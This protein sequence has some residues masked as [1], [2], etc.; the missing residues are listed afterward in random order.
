MTLIFDPPS[1]RRLPGVRFEAPPQAPDDALP[2]MDIAFFVGFAASGPLTAAVAVESLTEFETVFGAGIVLARDAVTGEPVDGLLHPAVRGF[3][4]QGGR[5]CWVLRVAGAEVRVSRFA[6]PSLLTAWRDGPG[7]AWRF[8]PATLS[9]RSPGSG[10]DA[11]RV[12]ARIVAAPAPT[13]VASFDGAI[14][15]LRVATDLAVAP[16]A[17]DVMR[18]TFD[19][20]RLYGRVAAA[21]ATDPDG[22]GVPVRLVTLAGLVALRPIT[23]TWPAPIPEAVALP[24]LEPFS[25][26]VTQG[27]WLT[28]G[29]LCIGVRIAAQRLPQAG[30]VAELTFDDASRNAWMA[31]DEVELFEATG[32]DGQIKATLTG[33][34]WE[35]AEGAWRV[36]IDAW[37]SAGEA[38]T[39]Q[40]LRVDLQTSTPPDAQSVL[41][42][43]SMASD[44]EA[45][46][47][48][49]SVFDLPDD[50]HVFSSDALPSDARL[51][52]QEV[53]QRDARGRLRSRFALASEAATGE[54]MLLPLGEA[55]DFDAALGA[56][57]SPLVA[58]ER[59]GLTAFGWRLFAE[60][61]LAVES[62]DMLADRAAALRDAGRVPQPLRGMHAAFGGDPQVFVDEPTLLAIPDAVQAGWRPVAAP[63]AAWT[64][65][66]ALSEPPDP[67]T[68]QPFR[69]CAASPLPRPRFVRGPDPLADGSFTLYWT[70]PANGVQYELQESINADFGTF[71]PIYDGPAMRFDVL[72]R[73]PGETYYRVRA[74]LGERGSRWSAPVRIEIGAQGFETVPWT[75]ED[76]LSIHR[77]MLRT[78]AGRGDMLAVLAVPAHFSV[79]QAASYAMT[80]RSTRADA[81]TVDGP[82]AIGKDETRA[83][84]HGALHHPWL[85]IRR[86]ESAIWFPPDGSVCGQLAAGAL[87]RGA[88]IAVANKPLR[89]VVA[90]G[91]TGMRPTLEQRQ[92]MLDAQV[93]LLRSAPAGF[94]VSSA[95]TLTPEADWRPVNVRRLMCL[96]RR[97]VLR[98]GV[99]YVFEPNDDTLR[100]TVERGFETLLDDLFRRG[101]FAGARAPAAYRV[102]VGADIDTPQRRDAG[103]FWIE[104]QVAPALPLSFLTVRLWRN[105]E[106]VLSRETH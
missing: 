38:R 15:A 19:D 3:F 73:K 50:E 49:Q 20:V 71:A 5:R 29:R 63:V 48:G 44:S 56:L 57:Q 1:P 4:S 86:D 54:R 62:C 14:L 96:L 40:L 12:A 52:A 85:M 61:A 53:A 80:L 39:A 67:C 24:A 51:F 30:D 65:L 35:D 94:V 93:N 72:G 33:S 88:W 46:A 7:A 95:D 31:L 97:L 99:T 74:S 42:D 81:T 23:A 106:R 82:A 28:D 87:E 60:P 26:A 6:L 92:R 22:S 58:L 10:A 84:S 55:E 41:A 77:L 78:A 83:L 37:Q 32:L 2:R 34:P 18:L 66:P 16:R 47:A 102:N 75:Q 11:V 27:E 69:D 89:D 105:G 79:P 100:R 68:G 21:S 90:L 43:L 9:A 101:A 45:S 8:E 64:E 59:D 13:R 36:A 70:R 91:A 103:Q 17:G 76:M 98:R 25:L 104:L